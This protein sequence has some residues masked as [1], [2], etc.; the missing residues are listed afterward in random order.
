MNRPPQC[1]PHD[2]HH[3]S[4][5]GG[6]LSPG[7][8]P[9][10]ARKFPP[11][12]LLSLQTLIR[13][14]LGVPC[15]PTIG[16]SGFDL[17]ESIWSRDSDLTLDDLALSFDSTSSRSSM[18]SHWSAPPLTPPTSRHLDL[19]PPSESVPSSA[20]NPVQES[21]P[22]EPDSPVPAYSRDA[23]EFDPAILASLDSQLRLRP[24]EAFEDMCWAACFLDPAPVQVAHS[25]QSHTVTLSLNH[26]STSC[27]S[28]SA[29]SAFSDTSTTTMLPYPPPSPHPSQP[30]PAYPSSKP[31]PTIP[32]PSPIQSSMSDHTPHS[33]SVIVSFK[34]PIVSIENSPIIPA[35]PVESVQLIPLRPQTRPRSKSI[36][37]PKT[38]QRLT[39]AIARLRGRE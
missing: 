14:S 12:A 3:L 37:G 33:P 16:L 27:I 4:T 29:D 25:S 9:D 2:H 22:E 15:Y 26:S 38:V 19:H 35:T 1:A 18:S 34:S 17:A 21:E 31:L 28:F 20:G 23:L 30:P 10:S 32:P 24:F 8:G 36:G 6:A 7:A 5:V 11:S 13:V 39:T